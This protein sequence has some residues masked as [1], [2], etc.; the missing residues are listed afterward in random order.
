MEGMDVLN[1]STRPR[2][3]DGEGD[4]HNVRSDSLVRKNSGDKDSSK[5]TPKPLPPLPV[6]LVERKQTAKGG[7]YKYKGYRED[8]DL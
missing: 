8:Y 1:T 4:I 2:Q 6:T 5:V 7:H 3:D